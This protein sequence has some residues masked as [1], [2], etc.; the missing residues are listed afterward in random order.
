[1][2]RHRWTA[3]VGIGAVY[4]LLSS[5]LGLTVTPALEGEPVGE[6]MTFFVDVWSDS[7][8]ADAVFV[9]GTLAAGLLAV[10][11]YRSSG[12]PVSVGAAAVAH[13]GVYVASYTLLGDV[14]HPDATTLG[15]ALTFVVRWGWPGLAAAGLLPAVALWWLDERRIR[16]VFA[17][18]RPN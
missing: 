10:Q 13:W 3:L 9:A 14:Q 2:G 5:W 1:M 17:D 16:L 12:W 15:D 7:L 6:M 11:V 18:D 8:L 4:V